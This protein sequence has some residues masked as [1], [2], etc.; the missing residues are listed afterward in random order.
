M[1][2][3]L[4]LTIDEDIVAKSKRYA[5]KKHTSV[6]KIVQDL[7]NK[8]IASEEAKPKKKSFV[9]KYGGSLKIHIPDIDKAKDEYLKKKYGY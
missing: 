2:I 1:T 3:K 8:Q 9:E 5:A 7:L 4:N 6:S